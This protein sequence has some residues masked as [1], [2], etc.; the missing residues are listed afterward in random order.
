MALAVLAKPI[1]A[2]ALLQNQRREQ[3]QGDGY[4]DP[5]LHFCD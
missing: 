5:Y 3:E 4:Q 1:D 2:P